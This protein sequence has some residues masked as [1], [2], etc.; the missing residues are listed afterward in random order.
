MTAIGLGTLV[1]EGN[2]LYMESG[3]ERTFLALHS[4][5]ASWDKRRQVLKVD[6]W[7]YPVGG[8]IA[9]GGGYVNDRLKTIDPTWWYVP[10]DPSCDLSDG[11]V[12]GD[13]IDPDYYKRYP[14]PP[15]PPSTEVP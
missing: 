9:L 3:P 11:F 15:V 12:A 5:N 4:V 7:E 6:G 13:G 8:R 2:C 14:R 1:R 10:P